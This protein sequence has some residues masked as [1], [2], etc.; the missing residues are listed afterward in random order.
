MFA[1]SHKLDNLVLFVDANGKQL[2]GRTSEVQEPL[3]MAKKFEAFGW[4]AH[5]IDGGDAEEIAKALE[6]AK[7]TKDKPTCIVLN[8]V[9]GAGIPSVESIELNHHITLEGAALEKA[10][11][12][13]EATLKKLEGGGNE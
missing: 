6:A 13:A 10:V 3:D 1:P 12:E 2:D 8:T 11:S 5:S 7:A 4:A 9:K